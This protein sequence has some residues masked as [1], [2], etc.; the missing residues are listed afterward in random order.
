[1]LVGGGEGGIRTPGTLARTPHFECGAID[2]SATS[3]G[4]AA[5]PSNVRRGVGGPLSMGGPRRQGGGCAS[6]E[7]TGRR[8]GSTG[9]FD[10]LPGDMSRERHG[11]AD[12]PG[13]VRIR[14]VAVKRTLVDAL[15]NR[16]AAEEA[17]GDEKGPIGDGFEPRALAIGCDKFGFRR[18]AVRGTVDASKTAIALIREP[19]LHALVGEIRERMAERR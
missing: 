10:S 7:G 9:G 18:Y 3:P 4:P 6:R 11:L 1:V 5:T 8:R 16:D 15:K 13:E 14:G 2:H 12:L 19:P 17:E